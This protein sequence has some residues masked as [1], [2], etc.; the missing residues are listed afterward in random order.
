[1][2]RMLLSTAVVSLI[3]CTHAHAF[4]EEEGRCQKRNLNGQ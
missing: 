4:F 3:L 2:K 1:M